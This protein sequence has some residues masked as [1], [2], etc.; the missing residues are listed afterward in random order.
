[1]KYFK[2]TLTITVISILVISCSGKKQTIENIEI[3]QVKSSAPV[4]L[5]AYQDSKMLLFFVPIT[6]EISHNLK[7]TLK[8]D[9]CS[10]SDCGS[11]RQKVVFSIINGKITTIDSDSPENQI[12]PKESKKITMY[13]GFSLQEKDILYFKDFENEFKFVKKNSNP[14][15]NFK[16]DTITYSDINLFIKNHMNYYDNRIKSRCQNMAVFFHH[17]NKTKN[18]LSTPNKTITVKND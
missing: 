12:P 1:M 13:R 15:N 8:L 5:T 18:A 2:K 7:D 11:D 10:S 4:Y 6:M 3:T 14:A 9:N 16:N 17:Y